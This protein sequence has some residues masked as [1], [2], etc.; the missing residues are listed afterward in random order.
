MQHG[1]GGFE[2]MGRQTHSANQGGHDDQEGRRILS[3]HTAPRCPLLTAPCHCISLQYSLPVLGCRG[4]ED[5]QR[6]RI[7]T[8]SVIVLGKKT[9]VIK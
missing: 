7:K 4:R 2:A 8:M 3:P 6:G 1:R 5:I 9:L